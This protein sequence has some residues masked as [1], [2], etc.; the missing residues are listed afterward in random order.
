M[1]S[2]SSPKV[3]GGYA[4][5]VH[6]NISPTEMR[7]KN[8]YVIDARGSHYTQIPHNGGS[9]NIEN[10]ADDLVA[11]GKHDGMIVK[12]VRDGNGTG[13][14]TDILP[15]DDLATTMLAMKRGTVFSP[16][17][18]EQLYSTPAALAAGGAA[19]GFGLSDPPPT[20]RLAKQKRTL[21]DGF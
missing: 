5:G 3:A 12:N 6:P 4:N 13:D 18:G 16:I 20:S 17:T 21:V 2:S 9:R 10:V 14:P 11:A 15:S 19:L 8:P 7:F 1:W